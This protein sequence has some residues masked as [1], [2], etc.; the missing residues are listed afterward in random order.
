MVRKGTRI[1]HENVYK[2]I[3][4]CVCDKKEFAKTK[5]TKHGETDKNNG[6]KKGQVGLKYNVYKYYT[7]CVCHCVCMWVSVWFQN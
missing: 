4:Y 3:Y 6:L 2:N 5:Q 7:V 1:K